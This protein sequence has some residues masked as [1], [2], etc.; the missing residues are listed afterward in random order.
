MNAYP[1]E[2]DIHSR[3][4]GLSILNQDTC[5][6]SESTIVAVESELLLISILAVRVDASEELRQWLQALKLDWK[7]C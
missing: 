6:P 5:S 7:R 3:L 1:N 4:S 2:E